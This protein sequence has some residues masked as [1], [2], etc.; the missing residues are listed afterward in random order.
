MCWP[1]RE[2]ALPFPGDGNAARGGCAETRE[3][4]PGRASIGRRPTPAAVL[5][6]Q[7]LLGR[8]CIRGTGCWL[9]AAWV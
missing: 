5:G 3:A 4:R 8:R 2:A 6:T 9:A 7:F 1:A